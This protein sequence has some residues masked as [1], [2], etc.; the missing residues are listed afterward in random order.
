MPIP[1]VVFDYVRHE[2]LAESKKLY[3]KKPQGYAGLESA[4][5]AASI[6][7]ILAEVCRKIEARKMI[8]EHGYW[9]EHENYPVE[10]WRNETD[11]DD[12]RQSY[13]EWVFCK[14]EEEDEDTA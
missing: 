4:P 12:T 2:L 3:T 13:W 1:G 6:D 9:G 10:E 14:L 11:V 7:F 8:E 5:D